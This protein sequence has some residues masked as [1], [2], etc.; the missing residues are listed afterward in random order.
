MN[1]A[2]QIGKE[3]GATEVSWPEGREGRGCISA[4]SLSG[5]HSPIPY[6]GLGHRTQAERLTPLCDLRQCLTSLNHR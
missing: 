5:R 3:A 6:S 1:L 2:A 4:Q